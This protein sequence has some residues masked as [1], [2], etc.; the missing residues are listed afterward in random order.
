M[1]KPQV[2]TVEKSRTYSHFSCISDLVRNKNKRLLQVIIITVVSKQ[3]E[4]KTFLVKMSANTKESHPLWVLD[5]QG[6]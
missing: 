6:Q 5:S 2:S 4:I 1:K 3:N